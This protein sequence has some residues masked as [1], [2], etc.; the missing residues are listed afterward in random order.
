MHVGSAHDQL[1]EAKIET[2]ESFDNDSIRV[3]V[4]LWCSKVAAD[5]ETASTRYGHISHWN[6][7]EVTEM[8]R[9]FAGRGEFNDNVGRWDVLSVTNMSHMFYKASAFNQDIG[10][11]DVSKVT[12]MS[13]MFSYASAFN[14][15]IPWLRNEC[16]CCVM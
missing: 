12:N 4:D 3:A 2:M 7:S 14:Q 11:W 5:R 8:S 6:T 16:C 10:Q 13:D 1:K 9:L 15:D